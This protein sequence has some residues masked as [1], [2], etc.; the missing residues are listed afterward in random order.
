[1]IE[2]YRVL[3]VEYEDGNILYFAEKSYKNFLGQTRWETIQNN[4]GYYY[5]EDALKDIKAHHKY[6]NPPKIVKTKVHEQ[7]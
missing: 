7:I 2:K 5:K 1:M 6:F 4:R 3:E